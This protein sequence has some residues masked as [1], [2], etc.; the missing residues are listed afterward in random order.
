MFRKMI[1]PTAA[2]QLWHYDPA[3]ST[4]N[5]DAKRRMA[6]GG[7]EADLRMRSS[8]PAGSSID[9]IEEQPAKVDAPRLVRRPAGSAIDVNEE[10]PQKAPIPRLVRL[11]GSSID[12]IEEQP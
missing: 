9:V 6:P 10:Q 4:S 11:A 7:T 12:V 1:F 5:A 3:Q 2:D 8:K